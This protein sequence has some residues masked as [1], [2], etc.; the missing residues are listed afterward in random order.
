MQN[1]EGQVLELQD[2]WLRRVK[3]ILE[4]TPAIV[5]LSVVEKQDGWMVSVEYDYRD[6]DLYIVL[7][8]VREMMQPVHDACRRST[9]RSLVRECT[10][11][12][13]NDWG[14]DGGTPPYYWLEVEGIDPSVLGQRLEWYEREARLVEERTERPEQAGTEEALAVWEV[15]TLAEDG[16]PL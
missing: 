8:A 3:N 16:S 9:A 7:G 2:P 15:G 4:A 10:W 14:Y 13:A 12:D 5:H 1:T 6:A 11:F